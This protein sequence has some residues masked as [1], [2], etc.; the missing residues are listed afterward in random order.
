MKRAAHLLINSF[1]DVRLVLLGLVFFLFP[2]AHLRIVDLPLYLSEAPLLAL[3]G[4]VASSFFWDG[5]VRRRV[6]TFGREETVALTLFTL[7]WLGV[8]LAL[9]INPHEPA[10]WGKLK[11]FYLLPVF[12]AILTPLTVRNSQDIAGVILFWFLGIAAAAMAGLIVAGSGWLTYD[13][14]LAG[15][16]ASPNLLAMLL[17]PGIPLGL[18]LLGLLLGGV[19]LALVL[20]QSAGA[21]AGVLSAVVFFVLSDRGVALRGRKWGIWVILLLVVVG[22][23]F[24]ATGGADRVFSADEHPSLT[25][26]LVIWNVAGRLIAESSPWGIGPG[27]FQEA[28]LGLQPLYPPYP[29]WAVPTPHNLSL[30]FLLEGGWI[31]FFAWVGVAI[32]TLS[33]LLDS[34]REQGDSSPSL[35]IRRGLGGALLLMVVHGLVDTPYLTNATAFAVFGAIGLALAVSRIRA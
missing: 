12:L 7:F 5:A 16:Y 19:A 30:A 21:F 17:A 8:F 3:L 4:V 14:R 9:L 13:G 6:T 35:S 10:A 18:A 22:P 25:S 1:R 27:R 31:T 2:A 15:W 28:Y 29:E 34:P 32:L 26:R 33:R 20:T 23:L 24:L 11:S